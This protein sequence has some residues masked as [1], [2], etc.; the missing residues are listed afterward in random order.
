MLCDLK[1][2]R[3]RYLSSTALR[4]TLI[5]NIEVLPGNFRKNK[6]GRALIA[7][8][9]QQLLQLDEDKFGKARPA[10]GDDGC[11]LAEGAA[12]STL[13]RSMFIEH[14]VGFVLQLHKKKELKELAA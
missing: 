4:A 12:F 5:K 8:E 11:F 3:I 13:T 10:F 7:Q 9:F 14:A 2:R 1:Y 6:K